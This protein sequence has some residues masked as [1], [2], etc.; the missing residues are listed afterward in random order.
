MNKK[1]ILGIAGLAVVLAAVVV[2][3]GLVS[4]NARHGYQNGSVLAASIRHKVD[5]EM[6]S[7][8]DDATVTLVTCIEQG[9]SSAICLVKTSDGQSDTMNVVI[10]ADGNEWITK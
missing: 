4:A 1:L 3:I 7:D 10:S 8:G 6:T 2:T 9:K 5:K